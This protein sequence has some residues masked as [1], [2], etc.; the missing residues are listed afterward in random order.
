ML[1][2]PTVCIT[3]TFLFDR[4]CGSF[5]LAL[6]FRQPDRLVSFEVSG[7]TARGTHVAAR[8]QTTPRPLTVGKSTNFVPRIY[9]AGYL[10]CRAI[11]LVSTFQLELER[12]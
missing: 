2:I 1:T 3:L 12:N 4:R 8:S 9:A 5:R 10:E 11:R 6:Y 7:T